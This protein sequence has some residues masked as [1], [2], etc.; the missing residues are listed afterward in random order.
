M[1]G[2]ITDPLVSIVIPVYNGSRYLGE[3][4]ESALSQTYPNIE[5][6][7]I[8]DGSDDNGATENI[9]RS[10]GNKIRYIKK[11]N[12]GVA[13]ALNLGLSIIKGDYFSW[14]SHDDI[15]YPNKIETQINFLRNSGLGAICYSDYDIVDENSRLLDIKRLKRIH[16][17]QFRRF[18]AETSDLHGC[19]L[20]IP[21]DCFRVVGK[22]DERRKTTQDYDMW[23]RLAKN[24]QFLHVPEVLIQ[25]RRHSAQDTRKL[26]S[27]VREE[28]DALY[29]EFVITLT[30][31]EVKDSTHSFQQ[32]FLDLSEV[33][34]KRG[35]FSASSVS[36]QRAK[37]YLCDAS[38]RECLHYK[39]TILIQTFIRFPL[40]EI[41]KRVKN[42]M[43]SFIK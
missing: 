26:P 29:S 9:S 37:A 32:Y 16:P 18:L 25:Y 15:Y 23:F 4:V 36:R 6:L 31:S 43:D 7:V 28:C 21:S 12:G 1:N 10:F 19:T 5:V 30:D 13:S 20:L 8:D 33:L 41:K 27:I 35:F 38:L 34:Y 3:A 22:F 39:L 24:F 17:R 14:L 40:F 11:N 42:I 2:K